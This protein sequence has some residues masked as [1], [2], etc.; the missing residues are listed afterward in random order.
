MKLVLV[1]QLVVSST[2]LTNRLIMLVHERNVPVSM[3]IPSIVVALK[4]EE[5]IA[6]LPAARLEVGRPDAVD[7]IAG[8]HQVAVV[9]EDVRTGLA[10]T[11]LRGRRVREAGKRREKQVPLLD[12][13]GGRDG[14]VEARRGEVWSRLE[15]PV[16]DDVVQQRGCREG[17]RMELHGGLLDGLLRG[18]DA[19][20]LISSVRFGTFTLIKY[21]SPK[22]QQ[23]YF[24][25]S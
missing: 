12:G 1:H 10:R 7:C 5:D 15:L 14:D 9:A 13:R 24:L 23:T 20:V 3:S 25:S 11:V 8:P 22:S 18:S 17:E 4:A 21:T 16:C 19:W 2:Q 6:A